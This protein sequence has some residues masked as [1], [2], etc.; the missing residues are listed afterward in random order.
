MCSVGIRDLGTV[1]FATGRVMEWF[2]LGLALG[3]HYPTLGKINKENGS[4]DDCRREMLAAWL[5]LK[6]DVVEKALPTWK[7]L[8]SA[9]RKIQ[10]NALANEIS[11]EHC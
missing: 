6:D 4:V 3:L 9:L 11:K 5:D 8:E 7:A 1:F 10:D 2:S